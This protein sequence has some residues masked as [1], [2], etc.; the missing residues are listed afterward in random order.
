[1]RVFGEKPSEFMAATAGFGWG[2]DKEGS[3]NFLACAE[4][5]MAE[6]G[7]IPFVHWSHY[8]R[9]KINLY[10]ERHGDPNGIAT[11]VLDSLFDLLPV[12]Q[13][14]VMLP[15]PSYSLKVVEEYVGFKR[16]RG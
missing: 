6:R 1:M 5:V 8:E 10:R 16:S 7:A 13:A 2:G 14:A 4:K 12:A 15:L 9:T 11:S 3:V